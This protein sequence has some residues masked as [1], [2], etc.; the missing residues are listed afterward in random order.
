MAPER[1]PFLIDVCNQCQGVW[2][3]TS[4]LAQVKVKEEGG[5]FGR[6]FG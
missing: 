6:I 4:E 5:W 2:L 3:D 1:N